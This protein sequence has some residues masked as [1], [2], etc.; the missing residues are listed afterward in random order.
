MQPWAD[1]AAAAGHECH[2]VRLPGRDPS[3][4]QALRRTT[5]DDLH[6][7]VLEACDALD[8]PPIVIGHSLGGLLGQ[9]LAADRECAALVLLASAPPGMLV[10]Q[11]RA[12][13]HLV[14]L[15]PAILAGRPLLPVESTMRNVPLSTLSRAEQDEVLPQLVP[16]SARVFRSMVLGVRATR[17]RAERVDCP[18]L[19]VSASEDRNVSARASRRIAARYGADHQVHSGAPH[20][21]IADSLLDDVAGGVFDWLDA[22]LRLASAP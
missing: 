21:I 20:W 18:V 14:R 5:L 12:L 7:V 4:L 2:V 1:R 16:D 10:A 11:L 3:D 19:S 9:R 17:V 6:Q 8:A 22:T 13:P 15:M